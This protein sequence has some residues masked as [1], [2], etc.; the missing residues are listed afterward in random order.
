[1]CKIRIKRFGPIIESD[2]C[3]WIEIKKVTVFIGDQGSGKSS[4]AKLISTFSWI[5]KVLIRGDYQA[6]H[7]TSHN[8]FR[9]IYCAY[10]RIEN[11]FFDSKNNDVAEFEYSG[12][13]YD[14]KYK[15]GHLS[16]VNRNQN[17]QGKLV[18]VMYVPAERNFISA[19]KKYNALKELSPSL[20][21]FFSD[22]TNAKESIKAPM[23]LPIN[24]VT[25]EYDSL[26][27]IINIKGDNY[28]IRLSESSSGFQSVAPL[29]LVSNYY[30]N[31]VHE[32]SM[33]G[34]REM[35]SE[36]MNRFKAGFSSIWNNDELSEEQKRVALSVLTKRFNR[37]AFINIVEEPEQN[38][39]PKSQKDMLYKLLEFNNMTDGNRLI[40]T[41][42]SP[43]MINFLNISIQA[44]EISGKVKHKNR[45]DL[46]PEISNI[47]PESALIANS[48]VAIYQLNSNDNRGSVCVLSSEYGIPSDNN[49]LNAFLRD[50]NKIF[51]DLLSIEEQ[52]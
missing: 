18:Q 37:Q 10:H 34:N 42:H 1:M 11:Y 6:R 49:L 3:N 30:A 28:K 4:I 22:F 45:L 52:L 48:D 25:I 14:F 21:D 15:N 43:Y 13:I 27:D 20:L 40:L 2:D 31:L 39:F 36:E 9:K 47:V 29:Y 24:D 51:D 33:S 17:N 7:F 23:K 5:E 19:V 8:R 44:K 35:S 46:I 38:L 12:D 32:E 50:G 26:N 41:T 16:I